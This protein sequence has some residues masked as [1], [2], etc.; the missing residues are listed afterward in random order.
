M[1]VCFCA[2]RFRRSCFGPTF[3]HARSTMGSFLQAEPNYQSHWPLKIEIH[4]IVTQMKMMSK[5]FFRDES[6]YNKLISHINTFHVFK[7]KYFYK[8]MH[9]CS[10]CISGLVQWL[11]NSFI[12]AHS[13]HV[14]CRENNTVSRHYF[15]ARSR[16]K[17]PHGTTSTCK[18]MQCS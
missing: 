5:P 7:I 13:T 12:P 4:L 14:D 8:R 3:T 11:F 9:D 17:K 18:N 15:S 6:R 1:F 16:K 10:C 2:F